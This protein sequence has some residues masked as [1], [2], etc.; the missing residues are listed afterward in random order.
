MPGIQVKEPITE[1]RAGPELILHEE[2]AFWRD[3]IS[4]CQVR[5]NG[6]V[7][8]RAYDALELAELKLSLVQTGQDDPDKPH[9]LTH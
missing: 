7:P 9:Q 5:D 1:Y 3:Y 4:Y 6:S 2:I 8:Q